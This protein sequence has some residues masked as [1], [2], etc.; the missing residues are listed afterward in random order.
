MDK[1]VECRNLIDEIDTEIIKLFEKRMDVV[2]DV[3]KYKIENNK[4][5][6][7]SSREHAMLEKNLTKIQNEEYKAYYIDVLQGFLKASKTMQETLII[8]NSKK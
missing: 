3:T 5:I 7:D 4:P 2:K 8:E 1:L 6:L